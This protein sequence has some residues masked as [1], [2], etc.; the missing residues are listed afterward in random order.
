MKQL[1]TFLFLSTSLCV[2]AQDDEEVEEPKKGFK[3]ENIFLGASL[4][5]IGIGSNTFTI[6][7]SPEF[8]YTIAKWLDAG[9][10]INISY[11]SVR[12]SANFGVRVRSLSLGT[13]GFVRLYPVR[14]LFVQAQPEYNWTKYTSKDVNSNISATT[15]EEAG[16]F[17]A[18]IGYA[19]RVV[20]RSNFYLVLMMDFM[21]DPDSPYRDQLNDAVPVFRT[22]FNI[23][24]NPSRKK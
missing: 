7:G 16:S 3:K 19:N 14:F 1:L 4:G 17:L 18:G 23:Y 12:A 10:P 8:G 24:L 9:I 6:G 13:G 11:S 15:R 20:G 2:F 21:R 5:G 22:G